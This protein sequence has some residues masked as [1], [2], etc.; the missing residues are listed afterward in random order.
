MKATILGASLQA[1][2]DTELRGLV[3]DVK[4]FAIHDGPGIRTTVFLKGCPLSCAWCHNPESQ[5]R[6]PELLVRSERCVA[7]G[8]CVSACP[9]GAIA[10]QSSRAKPETDRSRCTGC[11]ACVTACIPRARTVVGQARSVDDLL[12]EI[13]RDTLFYDQSGGGVTLSGGEPLAQQEFASELLRRCRSQR[14]HTA[15]DTCGFADEA[16]LA[17]VA[18][19]TDLFLYDVKLLDDER[20][21]RWTGA[22]NEKILRNLERLARDGKRIWVRYP[23]VPGIND[24][25]RDLAEFGRFVA[26]C[27]GVEAVQVLPYHAAGERKFDHLGRRFSLGDVRQPDPEM[28]ENAAAVVRAAAGIA[29]TIG[30]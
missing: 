19:E 7:C 24:S 12:A 22:S 25:E 27:P 17:A 29:V 16:A 14:I 1:C 3:F 20:H 21:R 5:R 13:E 8:T 6:E 28:V 15:V 30:G 10:R 23:L 2:S 26:R 4:R 18:E 9:N 11:G